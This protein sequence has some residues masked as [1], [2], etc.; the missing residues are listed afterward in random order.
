MQPDMQKLSVQIAVISTMDVSCELS[1]TNQ[2]RKIFLYNFSTI[3]LKPF[4]VSKK[5][6]IL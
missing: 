5:N 3:L 4:S 2:A 1:T 6:T